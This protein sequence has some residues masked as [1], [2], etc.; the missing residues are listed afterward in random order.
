MEN[1]TNIL[2]LIIISL[3]TII[4]YNKHSSKNSHFIVTSDTNVSQVPGLSKYVTQDEMDDFVFR[5][6][7][8]DD[9]REYF[10]NGVDL[11]QT[12]TKLRA[13]LKQKDTTK[14]LNYLKDNNLS[15][16]TKMLYNLTPL[17]YSSFYDDENTTKELINL[18][19]NLRA[20]FKPASLCYK[21]QLH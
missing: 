6:W 19:A 3:A 21:K 12:Q 18:G 11:N 4:L 10:R 8:I 13:L 20:K 7:D 15:V 2:L 1:F 14:I 5:Y 16:D 17:M 9:E